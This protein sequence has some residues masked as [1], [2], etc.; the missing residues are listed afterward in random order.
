MRPS[1]RQS[2]RQS[3]R[4]VQ[5]QIALLLTMA[6]SAC[7][8]A[9][10][11]RPPVSTSCDGTD[12]TVEQPRVGEHVV[13]SSA[14]V[15]CF[16]L[17]GGGAVYAVAP[18]LTGSA[19]PYAGYSFRL[20]A[21]N[22]PTALRAEARTSTDTREFILGESR[23]D[24]AAQ[25]ALD[26]RLRR[27]EVQHR[28]RT[29]R[30][31]PDVRRASARRNASLEAGADSLRVFQVLADLSESAPTTPVTARLAHVGA[32]VTVYLDTLAQSALSPA[33]LARLGT[34][35]NDLAPVIR[36]RFGTGSD[37]DAN[38]RVL[39]LLSPRVN[40]LISAA[41]CATQG[42]VRGYFD[43]RDLTDE[44][45]SNRGEIF[46]GF[47]PDPTGRWSCSHTT[48]DV[49][50]NLPPTFVHELQHLISYGE[51]V[52]GFGGPPEE[53][54]LNEGLSHLAE[55]YGARFFEARYPAPTGRTSPSQIFPDSAGAY[56]TPNLLYSYRALLTSGVYSLMGCAPGSFCSLAE[57]GGDWLFLRWIVDQHG[58]DVLERLVRSPRV[59]R[60]NVETA[61]GETAASLLGDYA[62]AVLGDSI[63]GLARPVLPSRVRFTDRNLRQLYRALFEAYGLAGGVGRPFPIEP[64]TLPEGG[65]AF[66]TMRPASFVH[67]RLTTREETP[68]VVL[69]LSA[70]DGTPYAASAGAQVSV[71][72]LR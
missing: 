27:A 47:V 32:T 60:S 72:R 56:I 54:W 50:S 39:F 21:P 52:I 7:G 38:G 23:D 8:D 29:L 62:S 48:A 68:A 63:A 24:Q 64:L 40:A 37:V 4:R 13:I 34:V 11:L 45:G 14:D 51:H 70:S 6:V 67:Y 25:R 61:T 15:A 19:L 16:A 33:D 12:V 18:Q 5:P 9:D 66:G 41:N 31:I 58:E 71:L 2:M 59:G 35:L 53:P 22:A 69:R 1:M 26:G 28:T 57:R 42:Y 17:A 30:S 44:A 49:L 55:E 20:G 36:E 46:Y 3:M 65:S 10:P 43:G